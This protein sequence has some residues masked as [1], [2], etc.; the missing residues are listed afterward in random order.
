MSNSGGA[1]S[2]QTTSRAVEDGLD[3]LFSLRSPSDPRL[4]PDGSRV[5]FILHQ[6]G[7]E[8]QSH[9]RGR[10]FQISTGGAEPRP[11]TD[12]DR[13]DA[14][15]YWSPDGTRIAFIS[16][17]DHADQF[18]Q[19]YLVAAGGGEARR[20]CTTAGGVSALSWSPDG[21]R[22]A[23]LSPDGQDPSRDPAVNEQKRYLRLW[24]VRPES[25]TPEPV[26][27]PDVTIWQYAWSPDSRQIV[28]YFSIGP[29]ESDWYRGQIGILEVGDQTIRQI[30]ALSRQAGALAWS[31]DGQHIYYVSGA[32]SDRPLVGGDI[33]VQPVTGGQQRNLT[34]GTPTN[35]SWL[36]EVPDRPECLLYVAWAGLA[37]QLGMLDTASGT[38]TVLIDDFYIGDRVCPRVSVTP[39]LRTF[40][41]THGDQQHADDLWLGT[42][43]S[44]EIGTGPAQWRLTGLNLGAAEKLQVSPVS[45][46]SFEGADGWRIEGLFSPPLHAE[47]GGRLPPLVLLVHGGPSTAFRDGWLDSTTIA[48]NWAG[49]AVVRINPRGSMGRGTAFA[50]AVLGDM[51]GK[52]FVDLLCGVDY[53]ARLGLADGTRVAISGW[54]YGGF[55]TAWAVTQTNRFRAAIMGAGICDFH[56][57]HAETNIANW[58]SDFIAANWLENPGAYR[59]R[60]AISYASRVTTPT[61]IIHGAQDRCVP[62]N[63][64]YA[65]YRALRERDIPTEL[66]VY[67][68]EG[69]RLHERGHNRDMLRRQLVWLGRYL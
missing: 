54:S 61:L 35:P 43:A 34:P 5:A 46:I 1:N 37:N 48:L 69:H 10:L 26:S 9:Q 23:F 28:V 25:D 3:Q 50:D 52:D 33:F 66:A 59:E 14:E 36:S 29:S 65:F 56:S 42:L 53:V 67:P 12:G 16:Q 30:S 49:Y 19:V 62:V 8:D 40:V 68:R 39:D 55:M 31:R 2:Q 64:A 51:G 7:P 21:S 38:T 41:M 11:L 44:G 32:W 45:R 27:P 17:C 47:A 15:P 18:P 4:S 58:D 57:F 24:T 20:V 60:S 13:V 63:Q 6:W 22:L